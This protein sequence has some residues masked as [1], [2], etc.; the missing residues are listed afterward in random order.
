MRFRQW[1][2]AAAVIGSAL[3]TACGGGGSS[4]SN[5]DVRL[6]NA[7]AGFAT[8]DLTVNSAS[9]NT[10]VTFG[11]AGNY[12]SVSTSATSSQILS[13]GATVKSTTPTLA[14]G[15]KYSLIA[16]GWAGNVN[17]TLLQEGETAPASGSSK[18]LILNL[19]PDAGALDFYLTGASD[20][21]D[22]ASANATNIGGTAG[23]G[24]LTL[25][26]G[27]YR[28]RVTGVSNKTD[29]R[30]DLPAITLNS[31]AVQTLII[32]PT[33]GGVLVNAMLLVQQGAASKFTG[34]SSRA[35]VVGALSG[36]AK[37]SATRD[38]VNL[39]SNSV[40]PIIGEYSTVAAGS[41]NVTININGVPQ[42]VL[43]PSMV[44]GGDYTFLV[45]GTAAA[46]QIAVLND[47][48]RLP[49]TAGYAKFNLVNGIAG[50]VDDGVTLL[51]D[52]TAYATNVSGG[53]ARLANVPASLSQSIGSQ[54]AIESPTLGRIYN[55]TNQI[56]Q[57]SSVYTIF[58]MGD[59]TTP[60]VKVRRVR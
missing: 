44:A 43:T 56:I 41:G 31:A 16:Y 9:I 25:N 50:L 29:L 30:L 48:N 15:Y 27:N 12:A 49:T 23:S 26:A 28:L 32:T 4:S 24:Y 51:V 38:G 6:V 22:N 59:A 11:S 47:D 55:N 46:P 8:L 2:A 42:P 19:A 60:V 3:L 52:D 35:R 45:W 53:T 1:A 36:G 20:S 14:G 33:Q 5:A 40:A 57:A 21:L 58:L 39:L 34:T 7:S 10:G 17:T 13:N 54:L 37:V 18:L